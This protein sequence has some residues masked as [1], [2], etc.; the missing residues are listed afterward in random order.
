MATIDN[1]LLRLGSVPLHLRWETL[2]LLPDGM[3]FTRPSQIRFTKL[4][5]AELQKLHLA[6]PIHI[7]TDSTIGYYDYSINGSYT[8]WAT[9]SIKQDLESLLNVAVTVDA[10][11]GSGF[12]AM[13]HTSNN[14]KARIS[15][16]P[17]GS[18]LVLVGGWNDEGHK[19][20]KEAVIGFCKAMSRFNNL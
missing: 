13:A 9:R 1:E 8:G 20:V 14:F 5:G 7:L 2:K 4:L 19:H 16:I 12:V 11:C 18:S 17:E 3:H 10:I 6:S 15:H